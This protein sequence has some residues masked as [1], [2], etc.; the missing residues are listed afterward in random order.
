[1]ESFLLDKK[2]HILDSARVLFARYGLKKVTTDDIARK[3]HVSKATVYKF[4][5]NKS[6]IFNA[7]MQMETDE[8][9]TAI[10]EAI[11]A[12]NSVVD[13]LKAHLRTRLSRVHEF[14]N[15]YQVTQETWGDYWPHIAQVRQ[16]FLFAE[17]YM[18]KDILEQGVKRQEL[19]IKDL[20]MAAHVLAVAL[21]SVEF[22]WALDEDSLT[23]ENLVD[24]MLDMMVYGISR[25]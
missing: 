14:V 12:K 13:K 21:A 5:R 6:E 4:F 8:L 16:R 24:G 10:K 17:K 22:Q 19:K 9:L 7:V 25:R 11:D 18:V 23:L 3:T 1:M 20:D 2:K 15:F